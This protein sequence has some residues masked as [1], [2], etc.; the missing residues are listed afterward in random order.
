MKKNINKSTENEKKENLKNPKTTTKKLKVK[1]R[2][3]V[4]QHK[5]TRYTPDPKT[6]LTSSVVENRI[7]TGLTNATNK[8]YTKSTFSIIASNCF[9]FFNL[10]GL[11]VFIAYLCVNAS[12]SNYIFVLFFGVNLIIGIVQQI[13]AKHS[14]EKLSILQAP[15]TKVV[16]DGVEQEISSDDIVLDDVFKIIT[17]NQIPVDGVVLDGYVEVNESILTGE[18]VP[19]K[20]NVG[21]KLLAGSFVTSGSCYAKAD[22]V[23]YEC[24]I[25]KLTLRAKKYKKP[26]SELMGTINWIVK[27]VGILIVPIA[28]G[29][30]LV[31]YKFNVEANIW[32]SVVT[33][34]GAVIIG[35]I[36]SGLV[37]LTT[38]ALS[39][40]VVRLHKSN[41]LVQDMYSLEM[42]A[43][44]DVLCLDKT[45]TITDGR[46]K[47]FETV[48]LVHNLPHNLNDVIGTMEKVLDDSNQTAMALRE[49]FI[50]ENEFSVIK[51]LPFNSQR[52]FSAVTFAGAGT[53]A[54]GAPEFILN[55]IPDSIKIEIDKYTFTG[56]RVLL[57]AYSQASITAKQT[58]PQMKPIALIALSDN[59]REEAI[60]TIKWFKDNDVQVK[61]ISGDNPVTV[62][63]IAKRAG[64]DNASNWISLEGLSDKEVA[65]IANKYTVFGRVS[66]DQKAVL[67]KSL[68]HAGHT[69]A[70]T[71]DGVN[72]ILAM[73]ES[74]CSVTVATGADAAKNVA[75]IVLTDNNFNSMPKVVAEGRRVINN[76][77]QS[78]SL[79]LMKTIFITLLALISIATTKPFPFMSG[80]LT[81]LEFAVIGVPSIILS[82]QPNEKRVE[83]DFLFTIISNAIPGALILLLNV[84]IVKLCDVLGLFADVSN[85]NL[86]STT[87]QVV[88]FTLG[89]VIYL[90]KICKPFNMGRTILMFAVISIIG[91]WLFM[92]LDTSTFI[93]GFNFFGLMSIL[94]FNGTPGVN[95]KYIVLIIAI[96][97]LNIPLIDKFFSLNKKSNKRIKI[98]KE[99]L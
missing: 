36:P 46:M 26:H 41:T 2:N 71:G 70:M 17:G 72:D 51:K 7:I 31:N 60:K 89:G 44:V 76:I 28:I 81:I 29:I 99:E 83:G 39:L 61:V 14:I 63:E 55:E 49:H 80:M 88:A 53:Y 73:R 21:D 65:S 27:I 32:Q 74:D 33:R 57:L 86:L 5:A 87:L 69:V 82:L 19:V 6:G 90:Y 92:L 47:V 54:I 37:L 15:I 64:I 25:Q 85:P 22:K 30:G 68:K 16:R 20:K 24:Y 78:A 38:M 43:R 77:Q 18:S 8:K 96:I 67:I 59:I 97:E 9:T 10:L 4:L 93:P 23:A 1:K 98:N 12:V 79:Y 75:H 45:G 94:P 3:R 13:R 58:L 66:P 62:S 52:K 35:M 40:G 95:W 42:L 50:P 84:Y 91:I 11:I 56:N 34:T 48:Q